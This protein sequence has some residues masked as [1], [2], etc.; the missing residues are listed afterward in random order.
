MQTEKVPWAEAR[1]NG[2]V[3]FSMEM[4]T[5]VRYKIMFWKTKHEK[6]AVGAPVEVNATN[7]NKIHKKGIKLKSGA[8]ERWGYRAPVALLGIL[9][10]LIL[11][12][13]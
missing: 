3:W 10:A 7:G 1:D 13:F 12:V 8:P 2:T 11:V 4:Q 6:I 5:K 9:S